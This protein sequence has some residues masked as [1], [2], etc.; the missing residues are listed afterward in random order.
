MSLK[1]KF[2]ERR[3][4]KRL[5]KSVEVIGLSP[6]RVL[7]LPLLYLNREL[8]YF[9]LICLIYPVQYTLFSFLPC[10][11]VYVQLYLPS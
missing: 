8:G 5:D 2:R 1:L 7:A 10:M 4:N 11:N 9:I 6:A 3:R